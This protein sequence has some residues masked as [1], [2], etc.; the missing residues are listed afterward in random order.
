MK[1]FIGTPN[2]LVFLITLAIFS[3]SY[4]FSISTIIIHTLSFLILLEVTRT[5]YDY[6]VKPMSRVKLDIL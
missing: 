1:N 4:F 6:T 3:L 2:I 5:I